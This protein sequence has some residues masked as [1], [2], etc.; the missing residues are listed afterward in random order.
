MPDE[1][2]EGVVTK[3]VSNDMRVLYSV[4]KG[5][6]YCDFEGKNELLKETFGPLL[7]KTGREG[8]PP[9]SDNEIWESY[10]TPQIDIGFSEISAVK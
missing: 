2:D 3:Q 4:K 10:C 5:K 7:E 9:I 8:K 6:E 1:E